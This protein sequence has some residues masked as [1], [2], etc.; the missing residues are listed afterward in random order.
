ML[1]KGGVG[2]RAEIIHNLEYGKG[3]SKL[4]SV[5]TLMEKSTNPRI[6]TPGPEV[7]HSQVV[8]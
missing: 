1:G 7:R 3:V 8:N 4:N 6:Q 5:I 2:E